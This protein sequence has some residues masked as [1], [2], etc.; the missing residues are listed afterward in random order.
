MLHPY[1]TVQWLDKK[2]E[3]SYIDKVLSLFTKYSTYAKESN[4][5][6]VIDF[7]Q[8]S[9]IVYIVD[10]FG[11]TAL[12]SI[13]KVNKKCD[14]K[15]IVAPRSFTATEDT[16]IP[17]YD[18]SNYK[19]GFHGEVKYD[20]KV[21]PVSEL[22]QGDKLRVRRLTDDNGNKMEYQEVDSVITTSDD[23]L[24]G[25]ELITRSGFFNANNIH[26]WGRKDMRYE[27]N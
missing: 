13:R 12:Q 9:Q 18:T 10:G 22:T 19:I 24:M 17:V 8:H 20:F 21:I 3:R 7:N 23:P 25:Y 26:M 15:S 11:W 14:W 1:T 27:T 6:L 2:E 16:L 4:G 5:E